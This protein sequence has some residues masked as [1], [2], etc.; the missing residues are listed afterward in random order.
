[1]RFF[2]ILFCLLLHSIAL[3]DAIS[4][5]D[6]ALL[7]KEVV[8]SLRDSNRVLVREMREFRA[9]QAVVLLDKDGRRTLDKAIALFAPNPSPTVSR[10]TPRM[11][12]V[13]IAAD[14]VLCR[15]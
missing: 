3:A 12:P 1:M 8:K 9:S 7:P 5:S 15:K 14:W 4:P 6:A 13:N 10:S 11:V 2:A